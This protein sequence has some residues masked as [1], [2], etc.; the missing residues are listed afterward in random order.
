MS[1]STFLSKVAL[2]AVS[3]LF[4]A[5]AWQMFLE[6]GWLPGIFLTL[7][8]LSFFVLFTPIFSY[9]YMLGLFLFIW[10]R[11]VSLL[12]LLA[13]W[14][15]FLVSN[16]LFL[17]WLPGLYA[18]T[19]IS[20]VVYNIFVEYPEVLCSTLT[21]SFTTLVLSWL[22]SGLPTRLLR[23]VSCCAVVGF[24]AMLFYGVALRYQQNMV[25]FMSSMTVG[26]Y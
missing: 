16:L 25:V 2:F 6:H 10:R 18:S 9:F 11:P 1:I 22:A 3:S 14:L 26:N 24:S 4:M 21:L 12:S 17:T 15:L 23:L 8:A 13:W 7:I 19:F 20:N 5:Y